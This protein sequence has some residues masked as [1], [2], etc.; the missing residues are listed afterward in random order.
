MKHEINNAR[1]RSVSRHPAVHSRTLPYGCLLLLLSVAGA[2]AFSQ[3]ASVDDPKAAWQLSTGAPD[4]A[5]DGDGQKN[6][7]SQA[8]QKETEPKKEVQAEDVQ[9][10][11]KRAETVVAQ[12]PTAQKS[13]EEVAVAQTPIK[14]EQTKNAIDPI[15]TESPVSST[16]LID[17]SP[18]F[19]QSLERQYERIKQIEEQEDAFSADLGEAYLAYGKLL[20][21]AGRLDEARDMYA[22]SLHLARV[23]HGVYSIEQRPVLRAVFDMHTAEGDV[24]KMEAA[25]RQ[26]VWLEKKHP[27]VR[28]VYSYDMVLRLGNLYIDQYLLQPRN[29]E[30]A[31]ARLNKSIFYFKYAVS[32]YSDR[33]LSERLPPYGELALLNLFKS[34]IVSRL[35]SS[36]YDQSRYRNFSNLEKKPPV[37]RS[38][39]NFLSYAARY[40]NDYYD[41]AKAEDELEHQ[42]RALRDLGDLYLLFSRAQQAENY[43]NQA[44]LLAAKLDVNHELVKSFEQPSSLPDF[45][46]A[47]ARKRNVED[48]QSVLVPL[49]MNLDE[50]GR[51]NKVLTQSGEGPY[52]KLIVRAKR[53][54]KGYVF[55]PVVENGRLIATNDFNHKIRVMLRSGED[56]LDSEGAP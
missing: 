16:P 25:L 29:S 39:R 12:E 34:R 51:V 28:D 38:G 41:K 52:P 43:Y 44:W 24:D 42:V 15:I 56:P 22:S 27:A 9:V 33:P 55:R 54:S 48:E 45:N 53:A 47:G 6:L 26:V 49:T 32:R 4:R 7:N 36:F 19:R 2:P 5:P 18:E 46:Y 23:N 8:N 35:D 37:A 30:Q 10:K 40:L 11:P 13:T 50:M 1:Q 31:L 17:I 14:P 3:N 21:Q 20:A